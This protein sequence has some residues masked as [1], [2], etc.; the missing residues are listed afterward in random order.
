MHFLEFSDIVGVENNDLMMF[1]S[2]SWKG[3]Y[4]NTKDLMSIT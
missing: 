3:L 4:Q 1:D 2:R